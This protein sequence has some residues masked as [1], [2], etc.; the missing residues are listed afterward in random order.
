[1]GVETILQ[2][3]IPDLSL[4]PY[5][6]IVKRSMDASPETLFHA[7]TEQMER[8]FA[9]PGTVL[10][11][12]EINSPF[13]WETHMG[14]KR[15]AHYGSILSLEPGRLVELTWIT[16]AGGTEGAET[17]VT[18]ELKAQGS[19]TDLRLTHARF[20][21]EDLMIRHKDAW[22]LVLEQLDRQMIGGVPASQL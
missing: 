13:F 9:A 2:T 19:G 3:V 5:Q 11:K 21:N 15:H 1:V 20:T 22:P 12:P 16:G 7:W 14:G 6:L 18:I 10:M 8:W 4:R 17:V